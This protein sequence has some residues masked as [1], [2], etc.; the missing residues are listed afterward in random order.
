[1]TSANRHNQTYVALWLD[2]AALR[3]ED[4]SELY[5]ARDVFKNMKMNRIGHA[6]PAFWKAWA[7]LETRL[8]NHEKAASLKREADQRDPSRQTSAAARPPNPS[9]SKR[10]L[11]P[12]RRAME[13]PGSAVASPSVSLS[14]ND[15]CS[16]PSVS[17]GVKDVRPTPSET[18]LGTASVCKPPS[19]PP[20]S[21]TKSLD[22]YLSATPSLANLTLKT[23]SQPTPQPK[24]LSPTPQPAVSVPRVQ[25]PV[26][27]GTSPEE[28]RRHER[29][30]D[31]EYVPKLSPLAAV[32]VYN[33]RKGIG[34]RSYASGSRN[35]NALSTAY[36]LE[37]PTQ[38]P[39]QQKQLSP[40]LQPTASVPRLQQLV[41]DSK[42]PGELLR[43]ERRQD[44][45]Y[46]PK[47]SPLAA[48]KVYSGRKATTERP[49]A[50]GSGNA[51]AAST[52]YENGGD[53]ERRRDYRA[54]HNS[55]PDHG[56]QVGLPVR[57]SAP[58]H[59]DHR[60]NKRSPVAAYEQQLLSRN[61]NERRD[62]DRIPESSPRHKAFLN[63][64]PSENYVEVNGKSYLL[65]Q[66]VGKGGSSKVY[67]ILRRDM[68]I[69]ALKHVYVPYSSS[70]QKTFASYA[71]EI[72]LLE[73]LK[74]RSCI[75]EL[76]DSEVR[77]REGLIY[78]V[79]EYGD[80][81]LAKRL[82]KSE[83]K[84]NINDNFRRLYWH[85]MLEA[86]HTIHE[87]RIVHG[88]LKPANFLIVAGTLKLI[89]FGIAKAIQADDTTK[90]VRDAQIGT[91][92][93][94]SPEALMADE[95]DKGDDLGEMDGRHRSRKYR[96]GR[97]SDIW[98]LGCILYQMVYGRTP[99]AHISNVLQKLSCIQ[100]PNH[101]ISYGPIDDTNLLKVLEGCLQ[102]SPTQRM[103]I[104]EL[105]QHPYICS[106]SS[107]ENNESMSNSTADIPALVRSLFYATEQ[108]GFS[109]ASFAGE[110]IAMRRGDR[111]SERMIEMVARKYTMPSATSAKADD[112]HSVGRGVLHK[113]M[114]PTTSGV[115][116]Q[117][118]RSGFT[119]SRIGTGGKTG[120]RYY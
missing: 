62:R 67:K 59:M 74:G 69:L 5:L 95:G 16:T 118:S 76:F 30:P 94:M 8:G 28:L 65:L 24:Q 120:D 38:P 64:I 88:D 103:S 32:K 10:A 70:S 119:G 98:S 110:K 45:E 35:A 63:R 92:N 102:R 68:K 81:D 55:T 109:V 73:R 105:L 6:Q 33:G 37:T 41:D 60:Y 7:S 21:T 34:E 12:P 104:P 53:H 77:E 80:I 91:P 101:E 82:S 3:A 49:Y 54:Q 23:P 9:A 42:S 61:S 15:P 57:D 47:L 72:A 79:M 89:D 71:N 106:N 50:S 31:E 108:A 40:T 48:V 56:K 114:T 26:D 11:R 85:Q 100:D 25:Q 43:H 18:S 27:D 1:M 117:G 39:P 17:I 14:L 107:T 2:L 66:E 4:E 19:R 29:R 93:Y 36:R 22:T 83:K 87:A 112:G 52:A 111:A 46:V 99:F 115:T 51:N 86:V 90:I 20:L 13:T 78:L 113:S 44:E 84:S 96:V 75:V 58:R 116:H 97:A